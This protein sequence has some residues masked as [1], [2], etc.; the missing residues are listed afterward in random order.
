MEKWN[1]IKA[2]KLGLNEQLIQAIN[3][4]VLEGR[5]QL[6]MSTDIL[7]NVNTI[8]EGKRVFHISTSD[9]PGEEGP[10]TIWNYNLIQEDILNRNHIILLKGNWLLLANSEEEAKKNLENAYDNQCKHEE[11]PY[12]PI[13]SIEYLPETVWEWMALGQ[14]RDIHGRFNFDPLHSQSLI[15]EY[16]KIIED[17]SIRQLHDDAPAFLLERYIP[18]QTFK[19]HDILAMEFLTAL[20]PKLSQEK[21]VYKTI[22]F[23]IKEH[24]YEENNN[25][26]GSHLG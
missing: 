11:T 7:E 18:E 16:K 6:T 26:P 13:R 9:W 14:F 15:L 19:D 23:M 8:A 22:Q 5:K 21:T 3:T 1:A 20:F 10:R 24:L 25:S 12:C 17:T 4:V 2:K